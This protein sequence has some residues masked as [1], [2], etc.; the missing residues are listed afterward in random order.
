MIDFI[1]LIKATARSFKPDVR[2]SDLVEMGVITIVFL[3]GLAL[4]VAI[5]KFNHVCTG[6]W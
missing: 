6:S 1:S 2:K 4:L 5:A 3:M